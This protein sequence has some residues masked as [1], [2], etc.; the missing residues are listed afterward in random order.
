M[1][2]NLKEDEKSFRKAV[3]EETLESLLFPTI[4]ELFDNLVEAHSTTFDWIFRHHTEAEI[5]TGNLKTMSNFPKWLEDGAVIYWISGKAA[6]GKSTLMKYICTN[7]QTRC[8]LQK[9]ANSSPI[10]THLYVASFYFWMSGTRE[11][12]SQLGL[13]KTLLYGV[14]K[15]NPKLIPVAFPI[16]WSTKYTGKLENENSSVVS[17]L[18]HSFSSLC[19]ILS[20]G[21]SFSERGTWSLSQLQTGFGS[22]LQQDHIPLKLCLFID[23]LDEYEGD[24][25]EIAELFGEISR[26]LYVKFCVSSRLH[27]VF[28]DAFQGLAGQRLEDL[29]YPDI[30]R[31][32]TDNLQH[33]PRMQR[34]A[35]I[36]PEETPKLIREIVTYADGVFLWVK[37][38]VV[39]LLK[40][41]GNH[42]QISDLR[43]RLNSLPRDLE[44]L[45]QLMILRVDESYRNE[46]SR[47]FQLVATAAEKIPDNWYSVCPLTILGLALA[48]EKDL[49][50]VIT[51]HVNCLSLHEANSLCEMM[52]HRVTTGCG[53]LLEVQR[54][55]SDQNLN[56]TL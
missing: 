53:G 2:R 17:Q 41:L 51:A 28:Q 37:L 18:P 15:Q 22:L 27:L 47:I 44:Q 38:V 45:Y 3:E 10:E 14:L 33:D 35:I 6:C 21:I 7:T 54:P 4:T 34:L 39:S 11:Q 24:E 32:V 31:Y 40:G 50:M 13:M 46:A 42:D 26:S 23:G 30:E 9:W 29:T 55:L 8:C 49:N 1:L 36:E 56:W 48:E 52:R 12:K 43:S 16:Q 19:L 20:S 5:Q 25:H